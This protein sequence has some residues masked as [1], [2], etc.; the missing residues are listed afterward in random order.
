M[1]AGKLEQYCSDKEISE[2]KELAIAKPQVSFAKPQPK[3]VNYNLGEDT[4]IQATESCNMMITDDPRCN[5][6]CGSKG[7]RNDIGFDEIISSQYVD[8]NIVVKGKTSDEVD[9]AS[10]EFSENCFD[11]RNSMSFMSVN[12][13]EEG[14]MWYRENFPQIPDDLYPIMARWNFGDL[15]DVTGKDVKNDKKRIER[16]KKPKMCGGLEV[17]KGPIVV[18]F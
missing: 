16:G 7:E 3:P 13:V 4:E 6:M 14:E 8:Y 17:K 1:V 15:R 2:L 11:K 12:T 9:K 5:Y 18:K 10:E